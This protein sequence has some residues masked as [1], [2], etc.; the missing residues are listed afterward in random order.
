MDPITAA[1]VGALG[2]L[3]QNVIKDAYNALKAAIAQKCGVN[4]DVI[5]ALGQLEKKPESVGRQETLK[6]E[7]AT[8]GINK[9]KEIL[10]VAQELLDSLK[11]LE[12]QPGETM[13]IS[14]QAGDNAIQ[15]GQVSGDVNIKK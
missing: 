1:V 9:D 3:G 13:V 2:V 5:E 14:Q 11:K 8:A 6:E 7:V 4:S 10:N 12:G 15:V